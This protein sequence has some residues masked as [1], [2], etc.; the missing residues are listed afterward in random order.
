MASGLQYLHNIYVV[1][2]N[3]HGRN[4]LIND[5]D[6]AKI[7]DY[8]CP[9]VLPNCREV[10]T[11]NIPYMSP[12]AIEYKSHNTESSDI[13]SLGVLFLQV[14]MQKIPSPTDKTEY[15]KMM[16]RREELS[17]IKAHPLRSTI[18]QCLSTIRIARPSID[19]LCEV[20]AVAK[21][22]PQS[23]TTSS[24]EKIVSGTQIKVAVDTQNLL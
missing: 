6:R 1:H 18:L 17:K 5:N 12:E 14:A 10:N 9:Q 19:K 16:K 21:Q 22:A 23:V 24:P 8:V 15:S 2:C 4:I 20:V 7:A 3:L 13:Y 11:M